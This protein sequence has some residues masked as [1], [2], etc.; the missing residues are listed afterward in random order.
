MG[1]GH[2][3]IRPAARPGGHI[4]VCVFQDNGSRECGLQR[5]LDLLSLSNLRELHIRVVW[6]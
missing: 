5:Q 3:D 4:C 6:D 1:P 2:W